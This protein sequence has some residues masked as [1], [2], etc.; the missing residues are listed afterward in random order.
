MVPL[1]YGEELRLGNVK[2]SLHAAGHILGSAQVR[3]ESDD[4]VCVVSGDYKRAADPTCAPFEIVRCD[5]FI[6]EST[7]GLPVYRWEPAEVVVGE[8]VDW[9]Q[10]NQAAGLASL[11]TCYALGKAQ[12]VLAELA[13]QTL[14]PIHVHGAIKPFVELYREAGIVLPDIREI[15]L[16][17][18]TSH[19]YRGALILA[20]PGAIA[21]PWV[22]RFGKAS[23]AFCSGW[24][25]VRGQRRRRGFDRGF[26]LSDHA[27][28]P[29]LL[30]TVRETGASRIR[31]M[32]GQTDALARY[33]NERGYEAS[34]LSATSRTLE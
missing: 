7:F 8:I 29:A 21:T 14:G 13:M 33:L 23:A 10:K 17:S 1:D 32:H 2:V 27:D 4:G 5:E 12:R 20:P 30:R 9:W 22:K 6:T 18:R 24:M 11:L 34:V 16:A 28:W 25:L 31:V 15:D 26:A 3:I 19:D